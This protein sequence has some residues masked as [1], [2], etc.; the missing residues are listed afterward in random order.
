M[1]RRVEWLHT[2]YQGVFADLCHSSFPLND[3]FFG[4]LRQK[5]S[6][7]QQNDLFGLTLEQFLFH[8]ELQV[9]EVLSQDY[10]KLFA[11]ARFVVLDQI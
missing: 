2:R 3:Y 9:E 11:S 10:F 1:T 7:F 8:L 6:D 4:S 5:L